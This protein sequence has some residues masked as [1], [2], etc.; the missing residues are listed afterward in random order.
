MQKALYRPAFA[1]SSVISSQ[2]QA[3]AQK[4]AVNFQRANSIYQ[5]AKETVSLAEERIVTDEGDRREFD[6]AWQEMLNHATMKVC[7]VYRV[8]TGILLITAL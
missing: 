3:E 6:S 2:A 5:A 7:R 4:A 8:Y 1:Y